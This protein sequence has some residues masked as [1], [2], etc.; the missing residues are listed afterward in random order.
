MTAKA[1]RDGIEEMGLMALN[2][3]SSTLPSEGTDHSS[4]GRGSNVPF[5]EHL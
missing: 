3:V 1:L 2:A 5:L 4:K